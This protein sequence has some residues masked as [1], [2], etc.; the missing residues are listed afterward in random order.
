MGADEALPDAVGDSAGGEQ[1][2]RGGA[3]GHRAFDF[4]D[5]FVVDT[6]VAKGADQGTASG[7]DGGAEEGDEEQQTEQ[8][9][10]E[11]SAERGRSDE[12]VE[13]VGLWF[14]L[15]D[16]PLDDRGVLDVDQALVLQVL[17]DAD[18]LRC[19]V[20]PLESPR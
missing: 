19:A 13:L 6:D 18:G 10:P 7:T 12:I 16:R 2:E 8:E 5:E 20:G 17:E 14:R 4:L 3:F 11:G 1:E 9:P 15:P